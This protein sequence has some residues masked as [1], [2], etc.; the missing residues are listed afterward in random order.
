MNEIYN[1]RARTQPNRVFVSVLIQ[2]ELS[3][4]H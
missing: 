1:F 3:D 4:E 2:A